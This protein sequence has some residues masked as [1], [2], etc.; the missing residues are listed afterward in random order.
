MNLV[1]VEM[2]RILKKPIFWITVVLIFAFIRS[3]FGS[4]INVSRMDKPLP[5]QENYGMIQTSDMEIIR[6]R[7]VSQLI[8]KYSIN[9]YTTYP[10][11]FYRN[12]DLNKEKNTQMTKIISAIFGVSVENIE[13]LQSE[14]SFNSEDYNEFFS[15]EKVS[16]EEFLELMDKADRLLGGGS[17]YSKKLIKSQ[18]GERPMTYDEAIKNYELMIKKDK[19]TGAYARYFCDYG[20]IGMGIIP[21]FL[22]VALWFQDKRSKC[23]NLLFI[24]KTSSSKLVFSRYSAMLILLSL[25]LIIIASYYNI[26]II[27]S[28]GLE[29]TKPVYFYGYVLIW[30]IPV[31]M[32][33]LSV[34]TFTTIVTNSPLGIL[35]MMVWWFLDVFKGVSSIKGGYGHNFILR[36]NI[37]GN[38]QIY[39]NNRASIF[40]NRGIYVL[41]AVVMLIISVKIYDLKREGKVFAYGIRKEK[42]IK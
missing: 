7:A 38:T 8:Q 10:N 3:Q 19:I 6:K 4:S 39:L 23:E 28:F 11:G 31:L 17:F 20:G 14:H 41:I 24:R 25:P 15:G 2:K 21:V 13:K 18:F 42:D 40:I 35:V 32:V 36:H 5:N 22:A 34:G 33:V 30:I 27:R 26:Q 29:N 9:S 16:N 37:I 1:F 12:I